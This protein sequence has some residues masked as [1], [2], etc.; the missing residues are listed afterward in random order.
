MGRKRSY[1]SSHPYYSWWNTIRAIIIGGAILTI[2]LAVVWMIPHYENAQTWFGT[3]G[4]ERIIWLVAWG[5][6]HIVLAVGLL[7]GTG[8]VRRKKVHI[9]C[10][11]LVLII[12]GLVIVLPTGN[13]G[14]VVV[15][16][17]GIVGI[18]DKLD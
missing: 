2:V 1:S 7:S 6:V 15:V 13:W 4:I 16:I 5:I 10:H 11:W 8:A 9:W 14:G 3:Y 18:V 17:A 12:V